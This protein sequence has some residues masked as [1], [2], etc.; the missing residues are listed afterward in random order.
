[1]TGLRGKQDSGELIENGCFR[2]EAALGQLLR[3]ASGRSAAPQLPDGSRRARFERAA[4]IRQEGGSITP[5]QR[6][7]N[8]WQGA[9]PVR[10]T[11]WRYAHLM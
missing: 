2:H 4:A 8:F 7:L 3:F 5:P 10:E 11:R 1:M 9:T 6:R